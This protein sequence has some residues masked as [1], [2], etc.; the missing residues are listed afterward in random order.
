M[1]TGGAVEQCFDRQHQ[2]LTHVKNH[3]F[4]V[5]KYFKTLITKLTF[6]LLDAVKKNMYICT[7]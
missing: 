1:A 2:S 4:V 3:V 7:K 6:Y 5:S